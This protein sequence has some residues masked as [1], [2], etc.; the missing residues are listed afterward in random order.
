MVLEMGS[1]WFYYGTADEEREPIC[2]D[3]IAFCMHPLGVVL[4]GSCVRGALAVCRHCNFK[5]GLRQ[6]TAKGFGSYAPR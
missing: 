6:T 3:W 1:L 4:A 2:V 5:T